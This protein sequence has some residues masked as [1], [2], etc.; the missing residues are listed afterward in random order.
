MDKKL[1]EIICAKDEYKAKE[2]S[3]ILINNADLTQ[4]CLLCEKMD[5][6]FDFIRENVYKRLSCAIDIS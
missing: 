1:F 4:F 5:Y 2:A 6:L 3:K